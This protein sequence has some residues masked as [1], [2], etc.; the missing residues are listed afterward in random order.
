MALHLQQRDFRACVILS[1]PALRRDITFGAECAMMSGLAIWYSSIFTLGYMLILE[2]MV[3]K[4]IIPALQFDNNLHCEARIAEKLWK[5]QT[6]QDE[7]SIPQFH[8]Q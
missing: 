4:Y 6:C 7:R 2:A 3:N 5:I 1:P 8:T